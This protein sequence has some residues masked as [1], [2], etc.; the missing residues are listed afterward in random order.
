MMAL[1]ADE[2]PPGL[3]VLGG[4]AG[5]AAE[6]ARADLQ[7]M[8]GRDHRLRVV[9]SP[10]PGGVKADWV[11]L[12]HTPKDLQMLEV[13]EDMRRAI[14]RVFGVMPVELGVSDNV[15][16]ASATVQVDVAS[17]HLITP[18]LELVEARLNAQVVPLLVGAEDSARIKFRFDRTQPLTP[19]Q[20]LELARAQD[21]QVRRGIITVNEARAEHGKLPLDG[22]DT[23]IVDTNEG[24]VP[25]KQIA[26][27]RKLQG[28]DVE[29]A[30]SDQESRVAPKYSKINLSP[31]KGV[32]SELDK[33]LLWHDEGHSGDGLMP[34][35]VAWARRM[36]GGSDISPDKVRKMKAWLARHES[37]KKG[38]GFYPDQEGFPSPGRVAWALWGGDPAIP[39]SNKLVGQLDKA[40][41][42]RAHVGCSHHPVTT[43]DVIREWASAD[44]SNAETLLE[45]LA[46]ADRR[47]SDKETTLLA[48]RQMK[49]L[50]S[51]DKKDWLPSAWPSSS[52]FKGKRAIDLERLALAVMDYGAAIAPLYNDAVSDLKAI[53]ANSYDDRG[54]VSPLKSSEAVNLMNSRID[55]LS[56]AWAIIAKPFY[57]DAANLGA[58]A[59][60]K[61]VGG[62]TS[63]TP[64]S[65]A[66]AYYE[67]A[68]VWLND[69]SGLMSALRQTCQ[70]TMSALVGNTPARRGMIVGASRDRIDDLTPEDPPEDAVTTLEVALIASAHRID[71][72]S[73]KIVGL[74]NDVLVDALNSTVATQDGKEI[75]WMAEWVNAGGRSCPICIQEG[76]QPIRPLSSFSRR[77]GQD[78]YCMGNCRCVL[79]F[80]T[81]A[82]VQ[83]GAAVP[84]SALAPKNGL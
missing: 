71:N 37:D 62:P 19:A 29:P 9:S 11:E 5:A 27:G 63:A 8:R 83:S 28:P 48:Y 76:S 42:K 39:W 35:T 51:G 66:D 26:E 47:N 44:N 15:P 64:E 69:P 24:P 55:K 43:L 31:P 23:A 1:D 67:Q 20:K 65:S 34:E 32:V 79:V 49:R 30:G 6:R 21:L 74:A 81:A 3:L 73:G 46:E 45:K 17:S 50:L 77:P 25:L 33:G 22:G 68:M 7:Q 70:R 82:E 2:I 75:E 60:E 4:V 72:W 18:I 16:R 40:D 59:A 84:M 14:W 61:F 38:K 57:L 13:V 52:E 56:E 41:E 58:S 36:A 53:L 80:W 10:Q 12:R 78:T 54:Q